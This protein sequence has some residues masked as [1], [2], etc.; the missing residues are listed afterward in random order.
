MKDGKAFFVFWTQ[1]EGNIPRQEKL[2]DV[3]SLQRLVGS[4]KLHCCGP[5][6]FTAVYGKELEFEPAKVVEVWRVKEVE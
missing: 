3:D 5:I 1:P 4:L 2:T 6:K